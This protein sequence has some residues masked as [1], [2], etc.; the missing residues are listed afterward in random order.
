[1]ANIPNHFFW[2]FDFGKVIES[3]LGKGQYWGLSSKDT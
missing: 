2:T 1:M 3:T